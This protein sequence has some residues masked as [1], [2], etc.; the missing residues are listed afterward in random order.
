MPPVKYRLLQVPGGRGIF[1]AA[2]FSTSHTEAISTVISLHCVSLDSIR[3]CPW[4]GKKLDTREDPGKHIGAHLSPLPTGFASSAVFLRLPLCPST[5]PVYVPVSVGVNLSP[6]LSPNTELYKLKPISL[7]RG[8]GVA[9]RATLFSFICCRQT[10]LVF[11]AAAKQPAAISCLYAWIH[12]NVKDSLCVCVRAY[13]SL[14]RVL[15]GLHITHTVFFTYAIAFMLL[16][17]L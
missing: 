7:R 2:R 14:F 9:T 1:S 11:F 5:P 3:S 15:E 16:H 6:R 10:C 12:G 4:G 17:C 8:P 13:T